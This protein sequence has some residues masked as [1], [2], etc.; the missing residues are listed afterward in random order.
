MPVEVL[1]CAAEMLY[2]PKSSLLSNMIGV[3]K[4]LSGK[5][6]MG[7]MFRSRDQKLPGPYFYSVQK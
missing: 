1:D 7:A 5:E 4:T 6:I 2:D 3:W